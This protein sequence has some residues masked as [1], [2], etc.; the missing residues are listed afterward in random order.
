MRL[1]ILLI[2]IGL[3]PLFSQ[4]QLITAKQGFGVSQDKQAHALFDIEFH[5]QG[6]WGIVG[7]STLLLTS[8]NENERAFS[9]G[10]ILN[11][12][13]FIKN[14]D[15]YVGL[16]AGAVGQKAA[17]DIQPKVNAVA[18]YNYYANKYF[19]FFLRLNYDYYQSPIVDVMKPPAVELYFG[20]GYQLNDFYRLIRGK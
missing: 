14:H 17:K 6:V 3:Q 4:E 18:G 9:T 11:R 7:Q 20:L 12:H 8:T 19:H 15:F 13:F 1:I 16:G 2:S 5:E 10:M